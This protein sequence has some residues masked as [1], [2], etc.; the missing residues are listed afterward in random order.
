MRFYFKAFLPLTGEV[1]ISDRR[2]DNH[3]LH[4]E[5]QKNHPK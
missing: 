1:S 5:R 4:K 2:I 3:D